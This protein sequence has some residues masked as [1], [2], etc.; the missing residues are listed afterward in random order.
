MFIASSEIVSATHLHCRLT[1]LLPQANAL[2]A[3]DERVLCRRRTCFVLEVNALKKRIRTSATYTQLSTSDF[4]TNLCRD[5]CE[6][7]LL[8]SEN[9]RYRAAEI[10]RY[11][12][13]Q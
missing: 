2:I 8:T 11:L 10:Q 4:Q 3:S 1:H 13:S 9:G 12:D 6:L 5:D 7:Q